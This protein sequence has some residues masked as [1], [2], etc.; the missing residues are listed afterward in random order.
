M[1]FSS[2]HS[3]SWEAIVVYTGL[4][5]ATFFKLL[6]LL[7]AAYH[8]LSGLFRPSKTHNHPRSLEEMQPLSPPVQLGEITPEELKQYDGSDPKK[9]LLMAIKCQIYDVSQSRC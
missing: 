8:V 9:A 2:F 7:F 4:S 6:A 5:P 3:I 1:E